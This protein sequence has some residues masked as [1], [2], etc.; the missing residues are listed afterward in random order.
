MRFQLPQFIETE[1]KL[2]GP[3]TLKQFIWI[4][5]GGAIIYISYLMFGLS[6]WFFIIAVLGGGICLAL[7]FAKID[8]IPLLSYIVYAI[9]FTISPR[10][11]LFR[12]N[13][14]KI[15]IPY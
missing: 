15:D 13:S 10:R 2:V 11:Y 5:V 12:K 6:I 7:A 4:A 14:D 8:G 3:F 9:N 1:T